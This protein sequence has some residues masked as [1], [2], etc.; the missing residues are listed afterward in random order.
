MTVDFGSMRFSGIRSAAPEQ[1]EEAVLVLLEQ[2][3]TL[4]LL[5]HRRW[6]D[7]PLRRAIEEVLDA[8]IV[9]NDDHSRLKWVG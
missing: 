1:R 5:V 4:Q 3:P 8:A 9:G 6:L 2:P 7:L